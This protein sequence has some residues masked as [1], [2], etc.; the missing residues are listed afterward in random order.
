MKALSIIWY[1]VLCSIVSVGQSVETRS[2]TVGGD[3]K[4][5]YPVVFE[6]INWHYS[7]TELEITRSDVHINSRWRGS[8]VAKFRFHT[9]RW[10]H[11]SHFC[12]SDIKYSIKPFVADFIDATKGNSTK[13]FIVWLRGGGTTYRYRYINSEIS[14]PRV[15]DGEVNPLPFQEVYGE[16]HSFKTA[17][18]PKINQNGNTYNYT[19]NFLGDG[20]N[21]FAGSIGIGTINTA[22]NKLVVTG[23]TIIEGVLKAKEINVQT[24]VWFDYVFENGYDL[25]SLSELENY[26]MENGHLPGIP[27]S[28]EVVD[29]G[30]SMVEINLKFLEKIEELV[31]YT[32]QQEKKLQDQRKQIQEHEFQIKS[33]K[34]IEERI[35]VLEEKYH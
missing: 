21:Y 35:S 17:I 20:L 16:E 32:I 29:R 25:R 27:S 5:F 10:G 2:F 18:N 6:D 4:R 30:I 8:L 26:I 3:F 1:V 33:L 13:D 12:D 31:L 7:S 15:Y 19:S 24:D 11:N 14:N 23:N 34:K 28:N 22:G 9:S